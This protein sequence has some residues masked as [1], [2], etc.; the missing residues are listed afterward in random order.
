MYMYYTI[1]HINENS[2]G[3]VRTIQYKPSI[4]NIQENSI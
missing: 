2:W 3:G 4:E 1:L